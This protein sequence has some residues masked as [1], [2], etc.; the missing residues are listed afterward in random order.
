MLSEPQQCETV[1]FQVLLQDVY[2]RAFGSLK[3][4]TPDVQDYFVKC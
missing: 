3:I 1:K 4:R 2:L